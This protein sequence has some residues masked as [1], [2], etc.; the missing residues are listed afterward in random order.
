M[1]I[2]AMIK[3]VSAKESNK[4]VLSDLLSVPKIIGTGPIMTAPPPRNFVALALEAESKTSVMT[5]RIMPTK[6]SVSPRA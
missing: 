6:T 4:T 3:T 5:M 2:K 1:I